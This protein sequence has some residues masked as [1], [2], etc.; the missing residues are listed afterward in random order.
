LLAFAIAWNLM[1]VGAYRANDIP[2]GIP[3]PYRV[4]DAPLTFADLAA[5]AAGSGGIAWLDWIHDGFFTNWAARAINFSDAGALLSL[6]MVVGA[7]TL[8]GALA[9][10]ALLARRFLSGRPVGVALCVAVALLSVI[11]VHGA[12]WRAGDPGN[13]IGRFHHLP[14]VDF[15]L[16]RPAADSWIHSD[17][18]LPVSHIDLLTQLNYGHQLAQGEAV[19]E[20]TVYSRDDREFSKLLRAGI[21]TAEA[22]YLRPEY[23]DAIG[24]GIGET[25]IV[26]SHP[27]DIY[28]RHGYEMLI[29]HSVLELPE[30]MVVNKIRLRYLNRRGRLVVSDIF[31]RDFP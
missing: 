22:S 15:Q 5:A 26:R 2:Q 1:L 17:H 24:H 18:P 8:A 23:R 21:E 20:V 13:R 25:D 29:F 19:A 11:S 10:R 30:P 28:S 31:L 4:V 7:A 14:E 6:L 12:I 9:I 27:A 3:D 16:Q